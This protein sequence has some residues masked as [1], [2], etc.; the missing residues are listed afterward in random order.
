VDYDAN[1][2][3]NYEA[4]YDANVALNGYKEIIIKLINERGKIKLSYTVNT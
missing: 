4:N 2:Y 1:Y 3:A